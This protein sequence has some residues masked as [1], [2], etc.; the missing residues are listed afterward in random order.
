MASIAERDPGRIGRLEAQPHGMLVIGGRLERHALYRALWDALRDVRPP[1]ARAETQNGVGDSVS[2]EVAD[3]WRPP[4]ITELARSIESTFEALG[5]E[6]Q[7]IVGP[8]NVSVRRL[9]TLVAEAEHDAELSLEE[10]D[11][12]AQMAPPPPPRAEAAGR[13][14]GHPD[15]QARRRARAGAARAAGSQAAA[16]ARRAEYQAAIAMRDAATAP[17]RHRAIQVWRL[18]DAC[19]AAYWG[20]RLRFR[21]RRHEDELVTRRVVVP[22]PGWV[23]D[24]EVLYDTTPRSKAS[25]IGDAVDREAY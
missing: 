20:W 17:V 9:A 4:Y 6:A 21:I 25:A 18:G 14:A 5:A 24:D 13:P 12:L 19:Q 11:R 22:L 23:L 8:H 15:A 2:P 1:R 7:Q 3:A 16:S 10:R